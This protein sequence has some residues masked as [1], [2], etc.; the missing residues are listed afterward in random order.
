MRNAKI[1][2][3]IIAV[4]AG[5]SAASAAIDDPV[6]VQNGLISGVAET[7][8]RVRV[9]KGIPFAAPP[10]GHLRWREPQPV[11]DW[12]G[13]RKADSFSTICTQT[14]PQGSWFDFEFNR[15]PQPT[16][17]DCLYLNVWT[18]A[19][20]SDDR[21]PVLVWLHGG[22]FVGGSGTDPSH[23]GSGL[24]QKGAVV[25]TLNYRLG[26]FGFFAHPE[27]TRES[28]HNASGNY[29]LMDQIA[30]L[31]W[32]HS[33][34]AAF[35]GD[36][37]K[38]TIF[39][40]SAGSDSIALLLTSPLATGLFQRA[41]GESGFGGGFYGPGD[42][43]ARRYIEASR[44]DEAEQ[45]GVELGKRTGAATLAELRSI[46]ADALLKATSVQS[47][48]ITGPLD[49]IYQRFRPIVDGYVV[50]ED[51]DSA[52]Q[53]GKQMNVPVLIGS[54]D[55]ERA[56]YP[57]PITLQDYLSWTRRQFPDAF[58][59]VLRVFPA[60]NDAE[61]TRA[62]LIRQ[63]DIMAGPEV[64]SWA[65]FNS[66]HGVNTWSFYFTRKPPA[67]IRETPL[68]AVHTAEIVY[69]KNALS[70]VDRPWTAQ[71]RRLADLMSSYLINFAIAGDPNGS[72]LPLWPA[73]TTGEIMELGD[74]VGPIPTPDV[75]E[76]DWLD[77]Y[78]ARKKTRR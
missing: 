10:V 43:Q 53:E 35:G 18:A 8:D 67:R 23:S 73:Y 49:T 40:Q 45:R 12:A 1:G 56:N 27:L 33:N 3:L 59:E 69:F 60:S 26:V 78:V 31:K 4:I 39:G 36:P 21:R 25:V 20:S 48:P 63:R 72:G 38:V 24:A 66:R 71:D 15:K 77:E 19:Q 32:V 52:Y 75:R 65:E 37:Q 41:M 61:A 7:V 70:T 58:D 6:R 51:V 42:A 44:L 11:A 74:H 64:R 13:V 57:H 30:A 2:A 16:G 9:F 47:W 68:G 17:E 22:G 34:I 62:F 76:L 14:P 5:S 29:G 54:V 28:D 50:S 55:N 46:P